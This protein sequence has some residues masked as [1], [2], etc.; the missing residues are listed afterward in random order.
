MEVTGQVKTVIGEDVEI[1]GGVKS[2]SGIQ[3]DGKLNGDL[4]CNASATIGGSSAV[5]GNLTAENVL[6]SGQVNGN[7]VAKD[8]IELKS[9]ARLHGDIRSRRLTVEDGVTFVGKVDVN[10]AGS[11]A[12]NRPTSKTETPATDDD[13]DSDTEKGKGIFGKKPQA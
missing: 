8:K 3:F 13:S 9:T 7:I 11:Q 5:K 12:G 6:V 4:T 10:P 2:G 1:T